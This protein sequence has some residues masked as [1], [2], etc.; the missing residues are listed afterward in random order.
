MKRIASLIGLVFSVVSCGSSAPAP[1][2]STATDA[3][4]ETSSSQFLEGF[5]PP[6]PGPGQ[7]QIVTPIY[8]GITSGQDITY[9]T[10]I[11]NP[12]D[13]DTDVIASTG[14]QSV[15]GHHAII[16]D[17]G[18]YGTPGDTHVC[19]DDDMTRARFLGGASDAAQNF[20]IPP[21]VAIRIAAGGKLLLQTHWIDSTDHTIGGQAAFNLTVSPANPA[22]QPTQQIVIY[23][24]TFS[25]APHTTGTQ[26]INCPIQQ[27]LQLFLFTGHMHEYGTHVN[28]QQIGAT[29]TSTIY[30]T[31]WQP[32]YQANPPR[33]LYT[34]DAP[35]VFHKGDTVRV[36]CNWDNTTDGA[37]SFPIEMCTGFGMY[38]PATQDIDCGDGVWSMGP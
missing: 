13:A 38:Y 16:Y 29:A 12:F 11:T 18:D 6:P 1:A 9:C 7:I 25:V 15:P 21:G 14:Y 3:G 36:T 30:D 26:V 34:K 8:Q 37:L 17:V 5:S 32:E 31:D 28:I 24:T 22:N 2:T 20:P 4:A 23:S 19:T 35:L 10:Y 27:D 33:N